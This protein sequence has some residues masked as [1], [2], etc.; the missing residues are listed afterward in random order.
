MSDN[1]ELLMLVESLRDKA[2]CI[3]LECDKWK[4]HPEAVFRHGYA[5]EKADVLMRYLER[6]EEMVRE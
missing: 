6:G 4:E 3:I 1:E 2:N 5:R